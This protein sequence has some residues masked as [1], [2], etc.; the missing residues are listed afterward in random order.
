MDFL[1]LDINYDMF[2]ETDLV[3]GRDVTDYFA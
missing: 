2:K 1:T 3:L